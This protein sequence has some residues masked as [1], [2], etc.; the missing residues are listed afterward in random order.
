MLLVIKFTHLVTKIGVR[1]SVGYGPDFTALP[2]GSNFLFYTWFKMAAG[3]TGCIVRVSV[4]DRNAF[5]SKA[6]RH[7]VCGT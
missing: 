3:Y 7:E 2:V 1:S 6:K 4:K 5:G